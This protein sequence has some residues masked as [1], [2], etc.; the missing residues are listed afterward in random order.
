METESKSTGA[1]ASEPSKSRECG[2]ISQSPLPR[3]HWLVGRRGL[4][5]YSGKVEVP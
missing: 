4:E 2:W 3:F 5:L 1:D